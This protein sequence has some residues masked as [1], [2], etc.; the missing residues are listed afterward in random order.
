MPR[1]T[2]KAILIPLLCVIGIGAIGI[3]GYWGYWKYQYPYGQT[4][5]CT[6]AM[7]FTL[8]EYAY[9]HEG[10]YP[11]GEATPEASLSL[12]YSPDRVAGGWGRSAR[13]ARSVCS[14][15]ANTRATICRSLCP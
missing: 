2:R 12:L 10:K 15:T 14:F 1:I 4:H 11:M 5:R 3:A 8:N 7:W 13:L 9:A 6:R